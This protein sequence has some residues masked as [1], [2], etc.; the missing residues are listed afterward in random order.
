MVRLYFFVPLPK[1][2][3]NQTMKHILITLVIFLLCTIVMAQD[4]TIH[5]GGEYYLFNSYY[6]MA[7]GGNDVNDSP[8]LSQYG[9]NSDSTSYVFVAEASSLHEGY[10]WLRQKSSGKYLQASNKTGDTW[11]IWFAGSLNKEYN[12][13][14]WKLVEGINGEIISNR[15][16]VINADGNVRVA[17]DAGKEGDTYIYIYYDKPASDRTVWQIVDAHYSL[18]QSR[19]KLYT[20]ALDLAI[21]QGE[22]IYDNPLFGTHD[23]QYE[24]AVALYNARSARNEASISNVTLL[25][26]ARAALLAAI[27]NAQEGNYN[28]WISG[29]SFSVGKAFTVTLQDVKLK[30]GSSAMFLIRNSAK[31]G[32]TY[33]I[34]KNGSYHFAFNGSSVKVFLNGVL[35]D[36]LEQKE[37]PATTSAGTSAEWTVF[38]EDNL[39]SYNPEIRGWNTALNPGEY[40]KN[41]H[42]KA[43][44]TSL[45][46]VNTNLTISSAIDYHILSSSQD[47]SLISL[48]D[49]EAWLFFDNIRPS[50]VKTSY[51]SAQKQTI[52][53]AIYLQGTVV[54]QQSQDALY[55]YSG[56]MYQG[57]EYTFAQGK[58]AGGKWINEMQSLILKRG[59]MVCLATNADGSGYSRIYVADHEDKYIDVLPELL[60]H[61]I[62]YVNIRPWN[63]VS[64]KGWSSTEGTDAINAEGKLVGA[65]WFYTWGAD[66]SSQTDMEYVPQKSHVYWPSFA[67]ING[68]S[69]ATS[70]LGYNEPEHSEQHSDDCG[71][72]IG[73]WTATTH[74]P[75]FFESGLRIGSPSPTDASWLTEYIGHCNDMAYR[76]DF[77]AF[78]A[79]WGTNEAPN[80]ASWK[81]QLQSIYNNTKRPIWLTEWNN[82]ASWTSESWP[83]SSNDKYTRQ[84]NTVKSILNVLDESDF[85]ERYAIYNWDSWFRACMSWDNDKNSWWVTPCGE[86]YRD[87][88]P[89]HAYNEKMQFVPIGWFPSMKT[90]NTFSFTIKTAGAKLLTEIADHNGDFAEKEEIEYLDA[91]GE[92]K[93]LLVITDRSNFDNTGIRSETYSCRDCPIEAFKADSLTLRLKITTLTGEVTTTQ[94]CTQ[95]VTAA[96]RLIV[97][98][99]DIHRNNENDGSIEYDLNGRPAV[100]DRFI[101]SGKLTIR[102]GKKILVK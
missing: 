75:E 100:Q 90:D 7:L 81:S 37:I 95:P 2:L 6:G 71:T 8:S 76:V 12:S 79:Y 96:V 49:P 40:E 25:E 9:T 70:V 63:W 93:L 3:Q 39:L 33:T 77:V 32:I 57:N 91:Q 13:Y 55:G 5:D 58:T 24:L 10:Y 45:K 87:N 64:K 102:N 89:T 30:D 26:T 65:T 38:G 88:R 56:E 47:L 66:R 23:E 27:A 78:H 62:S 85:I 73:A 15:G 43:E 35:M 82:G 98:I 69:N 21:S 17:P 67:S 4:N 52:R 80:A 1:S 18:E 86:V 94:S 61:R 44:I 31:T 42:G 50:E 22:A 29:N 48:N 83:S 16:E 11:S 97:G 72:T 101:N 28:I 74:A 14:E 34:S 60:R 84:M 51:I 41:A 53:R 54:Y 46:L 20:D 59:Y 92:W 19:L 68:Q 36:T 99:D